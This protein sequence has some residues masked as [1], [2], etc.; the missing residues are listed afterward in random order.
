MLGD[1]QTPWRSTDRVAAVSAAA[2]VEANAR[3]A[4]AAV[5]GGI[6]GVAQARFEK[7]PADGFAPISPSAVARMRRP[8]GRGDGDGRSADRRR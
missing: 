3:R 5:T 8:G 7:P 6:G 4:V 1:L 2:V